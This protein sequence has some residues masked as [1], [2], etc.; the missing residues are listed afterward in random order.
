MQIRNEAMSFTDEAEVRMQDLAEFLARDT[1]LNLALVSQLH[2]SE[3][4]LTPGAFLMLVIPLIE[5][6]RMQEGGAGAVQP[7]TDPLA[8]EVLRESLGRLLATIRDEPAVGDRRLDTTDVTS[9]VV[10]RKRSIFNPRGTSIRL[11]PRRN[12]RSSLSVIQAY[13]KRFCTI[14]PF[15]AKESDRP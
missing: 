3:V 1:R 13:W 2:D 12:V 9:I 6:A 8:P 5:A 14:P 7:S 11:G 4:L 10:E 15:C